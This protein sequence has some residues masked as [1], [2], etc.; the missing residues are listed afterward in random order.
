MPTFSDYI[1]N[2]L[3]IL[4]ADTIHGNFIYTYSLMHPIEEYKAT[5]AFALQVGADRYAQANR[6]EPTREDPGLYGYDP[7]EIE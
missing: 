1:N 2:L 7:E 3:I 4:M 6:F 5:D